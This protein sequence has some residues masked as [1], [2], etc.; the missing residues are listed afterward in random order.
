MGVQATA[1]LRR[2]HPVVYKLA[3][4]VPVL[5][6]GLA[7]EALKARTAVVAHQALRQQLASMLDQPE[8]CR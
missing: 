3:E 2:P 7:E 5:A 4:L 6:G 1:H 8:H